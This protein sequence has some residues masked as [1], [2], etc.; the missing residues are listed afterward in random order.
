MSAGG[1]SDPSG[2]ERRPVA[3]AVGMLAHQQGGLLNSAALSRMGV[4]VRLVN[5]LITL[6]E[7]LMLR[8]RLQP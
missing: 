6:L 3:T 5:G 4:D 1:A 8:R 7:Q 2:L